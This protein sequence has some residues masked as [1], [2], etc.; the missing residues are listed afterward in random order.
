MRDLSQLA[1]ESVATAGEF[2]QGWGA[3]TPAIIP[4]SLWESASLLTA[5]PLLLWRQPHSL[6]IL[7]GLYLLKSLKCILLAFTFA[8][9][10]KRRTFI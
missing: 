2:Q 10:S 9:S 5:V 6:K 3:L 7:V 1:D 8:S 4:N